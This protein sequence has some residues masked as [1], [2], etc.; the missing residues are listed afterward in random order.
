MSEFR[1]KIELNVGIN[2]V[3]HLSMVCLW[4]SSIIEY[5]GKKIIWLFHHLIIQ[6]LNVEIFLLT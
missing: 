6:I 5:W 1:Y 3:T 4:I 2:G